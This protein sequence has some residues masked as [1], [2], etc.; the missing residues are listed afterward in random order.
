MTNLKPIKLLPAREQVASA[1]RKAIL[2]RE[3]QEGAELTLE[4]VAA[5]LEVSNTPVR[6]ALQILSRDGLIKL[7]PNKGAIVL[8]I[9]EKTIR[10][11]YETRA[12]LEREAAALVCR[13]NADISGIVNAYEQAAEA[14]DQNNSKD[15]SN[16]NQSF[17]VEIWSASGNDTMKTLLSSLWNGLSMGHK[18]TEED[19]A[20]LSIQEHKRILDALIDRDEM[21]AKELMNAH[22]IRSM[23]NILTNLQK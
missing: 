5:Q 21:R 6:E 17:H 11:H 18:V 15:Y 1:L 10:N 23:E 16:Y 14:L 4:S 12:I 19:Y 3:L 13:Y 8:G 9:N 20:H 2:S 7:R 22:I